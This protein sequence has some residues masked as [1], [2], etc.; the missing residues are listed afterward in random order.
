M[1]LEYFKLA[2]KNLKSKR[3]RSYL[4]M[5]GIIIGIAAVVSL[6]SLG[7]GLQQAVENEFQELGIDKILVA[8]QGDLFTNVGTESNLDTD[9]INVIRNTIGVDKVGYYV[10]RFGQIS[11]GADEFGVYLVIGVE[12]G[13]SYDLLSQL[14]PIDIIDGRDLREGDGRRVIAGYDFANFAG[15]DD[16]MRPRSNIQ[17]NGQDFQVV[18]IND[19][20]G[21]TIDDRAV[22]MTMDGFKTLFDIG[23]DVDQ[24]IVQ[25]N[26]GVAPADV[27]PRIEENLRRHRD[28]NPGEEDFQVETFDDLIDSFLEIFAAVTIVIVGIASISLLVG[29]VGIMNTMYTSVLQRTKEIGVMKA[30]GATNKDIKNIFL[31]ESGMLGLLGGAI[32]VAIGISIAKAVEYIVVVG[33]DQPLLSIGFSPALILGSLAFSFI[34][35]MFSGWLPSNQASKL[36]P[37]DALRAE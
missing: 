31:F 3:L 22:F 13:E 28:L 26:P 12:M 33:L 21:N 18:G 7:Q 14:Q 11:W 6:I 10:A 5:L 1:K 23:D 9:D 29:G 35:G 17:I 19:R 37:V 32:G 20:V 27:V 34:I 8:P 25:V 24:I 4:T 2:L 15:F 16:K 36:N 30:I